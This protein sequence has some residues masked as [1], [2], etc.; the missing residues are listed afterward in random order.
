MKYYFLLFFTCVFLC[1]CADDS[2][3]GPTLAPQKH[4]FR[5]AGV[6]AANAD[7]AGRQTL[8]L[9]ANTAL[10]HHYLYFIVWDDGNPTGA[11][12]YNNLADSIKKGTPQ[13]RPQDYYRIDCYERYPAD[14]PVESILVAERVKRKLGK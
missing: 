1:G 4:E 5:I 7:E 13:L 9:C 6:K 3:E 10:E 12:M 2:A 14:Q 11:V 8:L